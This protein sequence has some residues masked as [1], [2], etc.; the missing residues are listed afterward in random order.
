MR[1]PA[2]T[3]LVAVV[4]AGCGVLNASEITVDVVNESDRAVVVQ[5][6]EGSGPDAV[7][8]GPAHRVGAA[9]ERPVELAVPGGAWTVTLNGYALLDSSD[10]GSR[11]G[12]LP[13]TLTVTRGGGIHW[14]ASPDWVGIDP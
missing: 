11:R 7:P 1:K 2:I 9:H 13:V 12:R 10:A 14:S 3:A 5:V 8:Y 4:V 6:V